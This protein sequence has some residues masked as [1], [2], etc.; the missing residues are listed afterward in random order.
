[1]RYQALDKCIDICIASETAASHNDALV[2]DNVSRVLDGKQR[3]D[4]KECNFCKFNHPMKKEKCPAL[5][6]VCNRCGKRKINHFESKCHETSIK[7]ARFVAILRKAKNSTRGT[8]IKVGLTRLVN[9]PPLTTVIESGATVS[10]HLTT[11]Q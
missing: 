2:P 4:T 3:D 6:K 5:G 7:S 11:N 9:R 8:R 10:P 1:M